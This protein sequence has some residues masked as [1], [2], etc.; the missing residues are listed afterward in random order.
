MRHQT[1]EELRALGAIKANYQLSE[2]SRS[3]RLERWAEL[4][5]QIADRRLSTLHATEFRSEAVRAQQR[6]DGSP[7]SIAFE[8]LILR[9][10]GL[11]NDTYGEAKRFFEL[12]VRG[13]NQGETQRQS[14]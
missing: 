5:E 4:L 10:A 8:D 12:S 13:D 1:L 7:I 2:M 14:G 6:S 3:Q 9:A 11:Q